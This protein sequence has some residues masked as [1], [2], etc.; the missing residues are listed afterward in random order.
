MKRL[1][2]LAV[3]LAA[4]GGDDPTAPP[5]E[6]SWLLRGR[7]AVVVGDVYKSCEIGGR[8]ELRQPASVVSVAYQSGSLSDSTSHQTSSNVTE[9]VFHAR[10]ARIDS[11]STSHPDLRLRPQSGIEGERANGDLL[12]GILEAE[13]QTWPVFGWWTLEPYPLD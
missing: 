3:A 13:A 6:G 1:A 9:I 2:L 10:G 11:V 5:L 7:A 4:C 12:C 8:V